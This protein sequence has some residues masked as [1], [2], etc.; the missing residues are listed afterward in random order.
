MSSRSEA[1]AGERAA[2]VP[3][4]PRQV[5]LHFEAD[6]V[7]VGGGS[8]GLAAAVSAAREGARTLLIERQA[9]LGGV[10]T[11][12]TLG[13]ICGLYSLVDDEPRQIVFGFAEEVR[14]RL[15][16]VGGTR[17]PLPW[18]KT[19]SLPYDMYA[20]KGVFDD[21]AQQRG[22]QVLL[23]CQL[24]D[25]TGEGGAVRTLFVKSRGE[26]FAIRATVVIDAS[27]DAAVCALAGGRYE[28]DPGTLQFPSTTFRMIGV[29]TAKTRLFGR[30]DLRG[31]LERAVE[32]GLDLPRTTGGV[33]SVCD[34][35]VH[36]NITRVTAADGSS[37]DVLD[38]VA[39]S[40]AEFAGRRQA[41]LYLEAF[42]RFVPGYEKAQILDVGAELGIR[43]SRRIVGDYCLT[44]DD[45]VGERRFSDAIAK[46]CWPIEDHTADRATRWVWLSPAGYNHIPYRS[47]L[48]QGLRNVI[49]AG[50]CLS[51]TH[52]AQAALRV[53]ANCFSMGQ[54]AGIA[55]AMASQAGGDVRSIALPRLQD[56]LQTLGADL[57]PATEPAPAH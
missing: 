33:Y 16:A 50:R 46:N 54:A 26:M 5:P 56:R 42:R 34:G 8:A 23:Q 18:L 15:D 9:F 4:P 55:A 44:N 31:F 27:G 14:Q 12:A 57:N 6:V 7:V 41:R 51:S 52:D 28:Y 11:S 48:P 49:V 19:A 35:V 43:E 1:G 29:D 39:L 10:M 38:A 30:D 22:L 3:F 2:P 45:V 32:A 17:G 40:E 21:L 37:P 24:I 53:T 47:L 25:V 36:L 13:G 20:L